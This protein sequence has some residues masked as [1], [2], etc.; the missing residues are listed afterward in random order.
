LFREK[1]LFKP[2]NRYVIFTLW[3]KLKGF[4]IYYWF[5]L[6]FAS[7]HDFLYDNF[8][9]SGLWPMTAD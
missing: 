4:D 1:R 6:F 9:P 2:G 3:N 8:S 5:C 7:F